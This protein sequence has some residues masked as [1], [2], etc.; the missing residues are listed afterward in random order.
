MNNQFELPQLQEVQITPEIQLREI[1]SVNNW[2]YE[3]VEKARPPAPKEK[4]KLQ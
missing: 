2:S 3:D 4:R 1:V